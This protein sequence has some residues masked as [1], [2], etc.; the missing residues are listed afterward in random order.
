MSGYRENYARGVAL[1]V[2]AGFVWS[3]GGMLVRLVEDA[4][5]GTIA[6]W[7]FASMGAVMF[8]VLLIRHRS[9]LGATFLRLGW[10]GPVGGL[11]FCGAS[12]A[13]VFALAHATVS[14]VLFLQS[15]SPFIAAVLGWLVLRERISAVTWASI[16]VATLGVTVMV[17]DGLQSASLLGN[18]LGLA[19]GVF[20]AAFTV[21]LRSGRALDMQ[22]VLCFTAVF[23]MAITG[24]MAPTLAISS[25]DLVIC[26]LLG[27]GQLALG[28]TLYV[29]GSRHVPASQ[30]ILLTLLEV[31]LGPV[32]AW[33]TVGEVPTR[34]SLVGG[35]V[36][37]GAVL[38]QAAAAMRRP[39]RAGEPSASDV[40]AGV[41][42]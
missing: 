15:A 11:L 38:L 13:F 31:V 22:P 16:A 39:R 33:A 27:A 17:F 5:S 41:G 1:V 26:F 14:T 32:W 25:H 3:T 30:I 37:I 9:D 2:A 28:N 12:T 34:L 24:L 40:S 7:R 18:V 29:M 23:G 21:L 10:R 19:I 4:P 8:T 6:F 35:A 36:V 42:P 20:F